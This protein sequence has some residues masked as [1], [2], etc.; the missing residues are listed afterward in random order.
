MNLTLTLAKR[1]LLLLC[2]FVIGF[3]IVGVVSSIV[4]TVFGDSIKALR[5][6]TV[7]QDILMFI[8]PAVVTALMVT[9]QPATLL[10]IDRR[11]PLN[12]TLICICTLL[13]SIPAMN[14]VIWLNTNI[15]LPSDIYY[16]LMSMEN[17]AAETIKK[18]S[19]DHTVMNLILSVLIV[20]VFAG[21]SEE[22]FFRGGV[23]RLL[24]TGGVNHHV[25]IW[26]TAIFFSLLHLQ[27]FGFVPRVLLGAFF[28]YALLWTRSLWVPIILHSLNNTIYVV[29]EWLNY[30]ADEPSKVD[31]IGSGTDI[32][33][34]AVSAVLT[35]I[36]LTILYRQ[37][38]ISNFEC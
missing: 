21:L 27:F 16:T 31:A 26:V 36:G 19:G 30:G 8:L 12:P 3:F 13:C 1:L 9:R 5:I 18:L 10:C 14:F 28:G 23:Q 34:V 33:Y 4:L 22:L 29:A 2:I 38:N 20:G 24:I 6:I 11:P 25:A 35:A 17:A 7:L 15:P 32:A 37:R